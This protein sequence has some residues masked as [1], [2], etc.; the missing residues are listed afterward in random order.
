MRLNSRQLDSLFLLLPRHFLSLIS[1]SSL[2]NTNLRNI[3][4]QEI[5]F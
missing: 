5:V 1:V 2:L 3:Y 4:V